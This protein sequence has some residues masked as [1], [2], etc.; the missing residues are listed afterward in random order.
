VQ[1]IESS[2]ILENSMVRMRK[3]YTLLEH[4]EDFLEQTA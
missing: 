1:I 2:V 3:S 4:P